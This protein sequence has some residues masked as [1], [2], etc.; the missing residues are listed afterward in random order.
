MLRKPG[1]RVLPKIQGGKMLYF[2]SPH[3]TVYWESNPPCVHTE[4]HGFVSHDNLKE[5]LLKAVELAQDKKASCWLSDLTDMHVY[6][7]DDQQWIINEFFPLIL[8]IGI[9]RLAFIKPK[10][11]VT[12]MSI[13]RIMKSCDPK[14]EK[15]AMFDNFPDAYKWLGSSDA[16]LQK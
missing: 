1:T 6:E 12:K 7:M 10:L 15:S 8:S 9:Q 16:V 3:V 14:K 5:G 11:P 2:Q 4:W 13:D